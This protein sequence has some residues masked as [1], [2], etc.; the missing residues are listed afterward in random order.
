MLKCLLWDAIYYAF[1]FNILCI[2]MQKL[3]IKKKQ[4]QKQKQTQTQKNKKKMTLIIQ[5][6]GSVGKGQTNIFF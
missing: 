5:D 3:K 6:F 1:Y 4:K 2:K